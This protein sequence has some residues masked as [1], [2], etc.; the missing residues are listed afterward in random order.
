M[1]FICKQYEQGK[2]LAEIAKLEGNFLISFNKHK[3]AIIDMILN[4]YNKSINSAR[5]IEMYRIFARVSPVCEA[6]VVIQVLQKHIKIITA[7]TICVVIIKAAGVNNIVIVKYILEHRSKAL[8]MEC[9]NQ[10][11]S[12]DEDTK[13]LI[14]ITKVRRAFYDQLQAEKEKKTAALTKLKDLSQAQKTTFSAIK[15]RHQEFTANTVA[16]ALGMNTNPSFEAADS[17]Q[18]EVIFRGIVI[19]LTA[20]LSQDYDK[21]TITLNNASD[22]ADLGNA[23]LK[24]KVNN[25]EMTITYATD[26]NIVAVPAQIRQLITTVFGERPKIILSLGFVPAP[27][28]L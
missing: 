17:Q 11:K 2:H 23:M 5:M 18:L 25:Q 3:T 1:E 10:I 15:S 12:N 26:Q 20:N 22:F 13:A 6:N 9:L 4:E 21:I 28:F 27:K 24:I 16:L 19:A 7:S 8:D 14:E